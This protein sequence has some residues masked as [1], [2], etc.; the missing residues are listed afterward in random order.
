MLRNLQNWIL[1]GIYFYE[2]FIEC[3]FP[4]NVVA[5]LYAY[6]MHQVD[7]RAPLKRDAKSLLWL[8]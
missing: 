7:Y 8:S 4:A 3:T 5:R 1:K 2:N 6:H